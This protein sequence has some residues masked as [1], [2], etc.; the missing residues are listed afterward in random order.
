MAGVFSFF[1]K[2][3]LKSFKKLLTNSFNGN[4]PDGQVVGE[5][6]DGSNLLYGIPV[7]FDSHLVNPIPH[8]WRIDR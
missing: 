6:H 5:P 3:K 1:L 8:L 2:I 7:E 4:D